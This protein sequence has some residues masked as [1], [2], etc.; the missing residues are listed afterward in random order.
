MEIKGEW[1]GNQ[2]QLS[3]KLSNK[4]EKFFENNIHEQQKF[5]ETCRLGT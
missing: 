2:Q 5:Y 4:R 1:W 3:N